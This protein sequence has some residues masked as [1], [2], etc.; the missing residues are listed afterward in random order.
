MY[1]TPGSPIRGS[2]GAH[3]RVPGRPRQKYCLPGSPHG[4]QC[5]SRLSYD[6]V[7]SII[8]VLQGQPSGEAFIQM[9]SEA[10]AFTASNNKHHRYMVFGKKQR[11][12]EVFQCSGEDMSMVLTGGAAGQVNKQA[13]QPGQQQQPPLLSPGMYPGAGHSPDTIIHTGL[14][15]VQAGLGLGQQLLP[16]QT[17]LNM[18]QLLQV[19]GLGLQQLQQP[20]LMLPTR[21]PLF[22]QPTLQLPG[23]AGVAQPRYLLPTPAP[24]VGLLPTLTPGTKRSH[25]AAFTAGGYTGSLPPKR[26]PVMYTQGTGTPTPPPTPGLLP[27]P[28]S[29]SGQTF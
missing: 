18:L 21:Q 19:P 11:Y 20:M 13:G 10:S 4:L 8:L 22:Q 28:G 9:D 25:E 7:V 27:T 29:Q 1:Q 16:R 2:G 12:I 26:P 14:A 24:G 23:V 17:D 3:P 6:V 15:G 5:S